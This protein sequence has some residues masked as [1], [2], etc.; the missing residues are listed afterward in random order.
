[1]IALVGVVAHLV[2]YLQEEDVDGTTDERLLQSI[3]GFT[4]LNTGNG[5]F[6]L[7]FIMSLV[8]QPSIRPSKPPASSV[9]QRW[10][11]LVLP[12]CFLETPARL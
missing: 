8:L 10:V 3:L 1:M 9:R 2:V 7:T 5:V 4:I 12:L 6:P 11:G